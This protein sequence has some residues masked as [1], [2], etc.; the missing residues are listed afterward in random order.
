MLNRMIILLN[1]INSINIIKFCLLPYVQHSLDTLEID[2]YVNLNNRNNQI[3]NHC[4]YFLL[5]R[6]N[7]VYSI[8]QS[9]SFSFLHSILFQSVH[10]SFISSFL[11]NTDG[12]VI[13]FISF[14]SSFHTCKFRI[15][16]ERRSI[17]WRNSSRGGD[18]ND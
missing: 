3:S 9:N 1:I 5:Q 4:L 17:T 7:I 10:S 18:S 13:Y 12:S 6:V 8:A 16:G 15:Y 14:S 11:E 2:K